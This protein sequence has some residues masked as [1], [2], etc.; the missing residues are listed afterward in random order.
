MIKDN[1]D[2]ILSQIPENIS[3]VAA[4]KGKSIEEI[5]E[6]IKAGISIIGENYLQ[7]A[8]KKFNAIGNKV[9]WHFIGHLQ[10]NKV[11]K[12][13]RLFDMIETLDSVELAEILNKEC[14]TIK[15]IMP[16]LIEVNI[17]KEE[18]KNGCLPEEIDGL[19]KNILPFKNIKIMGLMTMGPFLDNPE[20]LR[21]FFKQAKEIFD[22]TG[23]IY[24]DSLE[25]KYLSMGMSDTYK[26]AIQE[27]AN[28]VR[29]GTAIFGARDED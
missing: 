15:K 23:N 28:I 20:S 27:G 8:Q 4:S 26:I 9:K 6:G 12:A 29:I 7:E 24:A 3:I 5:N 25:W 13:V 11:K 19:I 14:E 18:N 21:P 2:N 22:K 17:A 10:K 1:V 16:V